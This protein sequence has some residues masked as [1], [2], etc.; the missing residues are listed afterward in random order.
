MNHVE[1][2]GVPLRA[3]KR[4]SQIKGENSWTILKVMAEL[5]D[6]FESL[7]RIGPCVSIFGSART[8]PDDKY[9]QLASQ[10]AQ[11]LV[12]EGFGVITGGGPGIMEAANKGAALGGGASVGLNINLPHEQTHNKFIDD[13]KLLNHRYFFVRK[14]MF[15]KYAQG[16][17]A[18]P[19]GFGTMDE[20][21]EVLTLIQTKKITRV[22]VVLV[23][24][25]YWQGLTDWL[26]KT[27][28]LEGNIHDVDLDLFTVIDDPAKVVEYIVDFYS[29]ERHQLTPNL[30]L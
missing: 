23:G 16:L 2:P 6:G 24:S 12:H 3:M 7:N 10:I 27:M 20:L 17:I 25:S 19:G 11:Q 1:Q 22:P 18:L 13:D 4:W 26:R 14:V 21:F 9:Y 28:L 15:V 8:Q 30:E 29:G 5:V